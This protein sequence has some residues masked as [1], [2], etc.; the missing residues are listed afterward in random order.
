[1]TL[2]I[3]T[4]LGSLASLWGSLQSAAGATERLFQILDETPSIRDPET[5]KAMPAGGGSIRF[6]QVDFAY[7]ARPNERVLGDVNFKIDEGELVAV[8]G[9]SGAGK[10][11][12]TALVQRF[13]DPTLGAVLVNG[14]DVKDLKLADLRSSIATVAQEPVLFSGTIAENIAYARPGASL[15]E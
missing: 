4:S 3:A 5:P 12:L 9:R 2:M 11:T 15:D 1:Y 10:S 14:V 8:V 7:P 6:D 13:Y